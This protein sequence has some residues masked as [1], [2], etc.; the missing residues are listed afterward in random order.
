MST[1]AEGNGITFTYSGITLD[2]I[3]IQ[4]PG[5]S[6]QQIDVTNLNNTSVMTKAVATLKEYDDIVLRTAFDFSEYAGI[7]GS[8]GTFVVTYSGTTITFYAQL[9]SIAAVDLENG[10]RPVFELNFTVTN[11]NSGSETA[12]AYAGA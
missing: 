1:P 12:P 2:P 5:W 11:L 3:S 4:L 9:S 8:E 10:V 6:K 7:T